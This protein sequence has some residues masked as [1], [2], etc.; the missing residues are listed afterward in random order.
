MDLMFV[1][2][3][4]QTI[5]YLSI[6]QIY[7]RIF[8]NLKRFSFGRKPIIKR[9]KK[10]SIYINL[11]KTIKLKNKDIYD[12][13]KSL[14]IM[15]NSTLDVSVL[16][17]IDFNDQ[18]KGELF[19]YKL[20][21][22]DFLYQK[23]PLHKDLLL[24]LLEVWFK[25]N[26]KKYENIT[27]DPYPV[28]L[29]LFNLVNWII[30]EKIDI[31]GSFL[32]VIILDHANFLNS[33]L[34]KHLQG[35][36]L[37]ENYFSLFYVSLFLNSEE[38][39]DYFGKK[40]I[41]QLN[42]QIC[43]DGAH[44]ELSPHYHIIIITKLLQLYDVLKNNNFHCRTNIIL[45]ECFHKLCLMYSWIRKVSFSNGDMP[46]VNDSILGEFHSLD[47]IVEST[48]ILNIPLN[49]IKLNDC[50]YRVWKKDNFEIFIDIGKIGPDNIPGH[51][52][53][54]TFNFILYCKGL[55]IIIDSGTSDYTVSNIRQFERS[56]IAHNTISFRGKDQSYMWDRFRVGSRAKVKIHEEN[57]NFISASHNGY[58]KFGIRHLRKFNFENHFLI[59]DFITPTSDGCK[60]HIHFAPNLK[61]ELRNNELIVE[62]LIKIVFSGHS[63]MKIIDGQVAI[64]YGRH[65]KSYYLES[66]VQKHSHFHFEL[67]I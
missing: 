54:D 17:Q 1:S 42:V 53:A 43:S 13:D 28:S 18:S 47:E 64:G 61:L 44:Y 27:Y 21:Y 63:L 59:E 8:F 45:N 51:A 48:N 62:N 56:T 12:F 9:F 50:G 14:I 16:S 25:G 32:E 52:H 55:P 3:Y 31:A 46:M 66:E 11:V 39:I 24:E 37:L 22:F 2:K 36:H 34:E 65:I 7:Y 23:T 60:S 38:N 4:I 5:L 19:T 33:N 10:P 58:K 30:S 15:L 35:N 6:E 20:N 40:V 49:D 57:D 41:N 29:R 67:L 26:F